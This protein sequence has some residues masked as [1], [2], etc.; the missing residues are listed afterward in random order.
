MNTSPDNQVND[1]RVGQF[2]QHIIQAIDEFHTQ[3][4]DHQASV[5]VH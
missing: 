2:G 4:H 3:H 1:D 5:S